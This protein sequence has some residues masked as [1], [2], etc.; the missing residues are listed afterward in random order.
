MASSSLAW[1]ALECQT[2]II[3]PLFSAPLPMLILANI[4]SYSGSPTSGVAYIILVDILLRPLQ[5]LELVNADLNGLAG[6]VVT[7]TVG[8]LGGKVVLPS[9]SITVIDA[10]VVRLHGVEGELNDMRVRQRS[11]K[12]RV[13]V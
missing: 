12:V 2:A 11:R 4:S 13:C 9:V 10:V 1:T 6:S 5:N 7:R 3:L 8:K